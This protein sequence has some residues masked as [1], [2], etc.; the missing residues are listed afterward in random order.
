MTR[1]AAKQIVKR[2]KFSNDFPAL[3]P[4]NNNQR[5]LQDVLRVSSLVLA[6][7]CAGTGKTFVACHHAA[8]ALSTGV[9]K[10]IVL[11]RA[12][13]PLAGR[14]IGFL[15][16]TLEEKLLP[17]YQQMV[18]YFCT[19][20]GKGVTDIHLKQ[21]TIEICSLETI[22][23]RSWDRSVI[24]VDEA[25]SLM[26]PEAQALV[27]RIGLNSQMVF[28]GDNGGTQT[29]VKK[30]LDGLTYLERIIE[31]YQIPD[32]SSVRFGLDD[33]VRSGITQD[34]VYAFEREL[35]RKDSVR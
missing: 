13:Q 10:R 8:K 23:G 19:F 35:Q 4:L 24:I 20:L 11:I 2:E 33:I 29:D 32:C 34:F 26:I 12:Y 3:E 25:Q 6:S 16:G 5:K 21:R 17:Y 18:D 28:C 1:R 22:R 15:P 30:G 14:S 7:G 31:R 27:T 9:A